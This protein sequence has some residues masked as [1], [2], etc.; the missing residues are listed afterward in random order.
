M[1][2]FLRGASLYLYHDYQPLLLSTIMQDQGGTKLPVAFLG[3][4]TT[5]Y[6]YPGMQ[7]VYMYVLMCMYLLHSIPQNRV[8]RCTSLF[9]AHRLLG[10]YCLVDKTC[11]TLGKKCTALSRE[12]SAYKDLFTN[13]QKRA[14][15]VKR[16]IKTSDMALLPIESFALVDCKSNAIC[17][18]F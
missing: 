17:I 2:S 15:N 9:S 6:V 14:G 1:T 18:S 5:G 4:H 10:A 13:N 3:I 8:I 11:L 12:G 16:T 7:Q